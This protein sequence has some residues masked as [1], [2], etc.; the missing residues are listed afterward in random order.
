M[1]FVDAGGVRHSV[2]A[3]ASS[4]LETAAAGLKQI[5]ETE[6]IENDGVL[7]LTVDLIT[8]TSHKISLRLKVWLEC[9]KRLRKRS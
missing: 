3:C 9:G 8:S 5:R 1:S 4:V 6:M 2:A 7:D